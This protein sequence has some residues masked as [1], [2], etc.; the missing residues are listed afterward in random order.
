METQWGGPIVQRRT[1]WLAY[2]VRGYLASLIGILRPSLSRRS[3]RSEGVSPADPDDYIHPLNFIG[4]R[5]V[6]ILIAAIVLVVLAI[7]FPINALAIRLG[8]PGPIF[9][10]QLRV[11]RRT[12]RQTDLFFITKFRTMRTDAEKLT[13]AVWLKG[14]KDP[15]ITRIG[16]FLRKTRIDELPQ[17]LTVLR[18]DMSIV[19][20]RPERPAFFRSWKRRSL[21]TQSAPT[22]SNP[23]SLAWRRSITVT[24]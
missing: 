9:Y 5:A 19:G 16:H 11:G 22:R 3:F 10:R 18:G 13:G 24:I 6:D 23:A 20:P 14:T 4:K 1:A 7:I 12:S 2:L 21:S 8:A 15:R 17:A